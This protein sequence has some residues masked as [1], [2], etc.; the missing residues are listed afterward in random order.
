DQ[1]DDIRLVVDH[2]HS[3]HGPTRLARRVAS[4]SSSTDRRQVSA[5][6]DD[7][8]RLFTKYARIRPSRSISALSGTALMPHDRVIAPMLPPSF[9]GSMNTLNEIPLGSARWYASSAA[10]IVT[11]PLGSGVPG[12]RLVISDSRTSDHWLS[13]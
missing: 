13:E 7:Q 3:R 9:G 6:L 12:A 4:H 2:E 11:S 10:G 8:S 1:P 5:T